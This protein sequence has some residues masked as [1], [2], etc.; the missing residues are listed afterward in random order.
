MALISWKV[1]FRAVSIIL[2]TLLTFY[3]FKRSICFI[4]AKI[5]HN[6]WNCEEPSNWPFVRLGKVQGGYLGLC[7]LGMCCWPL[8]K[9]FTINEIDQGLPFLHNC[10]PPAPRPKC[11]KRR[12][13]SK[14]LGNGSKLLITTFRHWRSVKNSA[15]LNYPKFWPGSLFSTVTS[16]DV[17]N[18]DSPFKITW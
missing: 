14:S 18:Q 9:I 4:G 12:R 16:P 1:Y 8:K 7:L 2:D 5:R 11:R 13:P 15:I 3:Y 10:A 17:Q 6:Q